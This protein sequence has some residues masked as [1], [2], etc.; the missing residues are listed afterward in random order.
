MTK[1][2]NEIDNFAQISID[3]FDN[4]DKNFET[5]TFSDKYNKRKMAELKTYKKQMN[6]I[7]Y[8]G[9]E[10]VA[11][12]AVAALAISSPF[13]VNA[14]TN[15]ELFN[16]IWGNEGKKSINSYKIEQVESEK[17]DDKGNVSKNTITMPKVEY[18]KADPEKAEKLI[19]DNVAREPKEIQMGDT[20]MTVN[21]VTRDSNG[22]VAE[23]TLE[24]KGGVD[25]LNYSELDNQLKGAWINE[26]QD[27]R[28][29]FAEGSGKI[30][31]DMKKSTKD[32]LYCYEYM[33]ADDIVH[34]G[35]SYVDKISD[36]ITLVYYIKGVEEK[37]EIPV[38]DEIKTTLFENAKGG[39][40]EISPIAMRI[41]DA[42]GIL[43]D[44][45]NLYEMAGFIS[46]ME[47][48]YKDGSKYL[49]SQES[50]TDE[51][52]NEIK[53]DEEIA[54]YEYICGGSEGVITLFNRLVDV[55]EIEKISI[56]G[57]DYTLK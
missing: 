50:C 35:E 12:V 40:I 32:K 6:K 43:S 9:L 49:V 10:K 27:L 57:V 46:K 29:V 45:D 14:L 1:K 38:K 34:A 47:I 18:E 44:E 56:N 52:L 39:K 7:N 28:Y 5:H 42:K 11:V 33:A 20:K 48:T 22:I 41:C 31:V 24:K 36:H 25:C 51:N 19:G 23:Y 15:G 30:Y 53:V 16:R 8:H 2:I 21:S 4:M 13:A 55:S 37:V 26:K 17:I 54:N 3:E